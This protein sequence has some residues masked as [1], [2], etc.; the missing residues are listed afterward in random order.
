MATP[1]DDVLRRP[2]LAA[3]PAG[4][5]GPSFLWSTAGEQGW[6]LIAGGWR[7]RVTEWEQRLDDAGLTDAGPTVTPWGWPGRELHSAATAAQPGGADELE[8]IIDE[9]PA[10]GGLLDA[11]G[12]REAVDAVLG[13]EAAAELAGLPPLGSVSLTRNRPLSAG[14]ASGLRAADLRFSTLPY[15]HGDSGRPIQS[16][17]RWLRVAATDTALVALWGPLEGQWEPEHVRWPH[18][19]VPSRRAASLATAAGPASVDTRLANLLADCLEHEQYYLDT[20]QMELEAWEAGIYASLAAGEAV[21]KEIDLSDPVRAQAGRLAS[22]LSRTQ[23]D[24]RAL[25]RRGQVEPLFAADQV[26]AVLQPGLAD[27]LATQAVNQRLRREAFSLLTS[28]A[29]GEQLQASRDQADATHA[30]RQAT[31]GLQQTIT[32]VTALLLAPTVVIG[33]FG[34]NLHEFAAGNGTLVQLGQWMLLAAGISM[35]VLWWR[36]PPATPARWLPAV[37]IVLAAAAITGSI[38]LAVQGRGGQAL[39]WA[40]SVSA[41]VVA[42]LIARLRPRRHRPGRRR[43]ATADR[44]RETAAWT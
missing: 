37:P 9:V 15:R 22:F 16:A 34:A 18:H 40:A 21:L 17:T 31:E 32:W 39:L 27:A 1:P 4:W 44:T 41:W 5:A 26:Q 43:I 38:T 10:G 25:K 2:T 12:V 33:V 7:W 14:A 13:P 19:A 30:Q 36:I 6:R 29:T 24:L 20:W 8:V 23:V 11:D 35:S 28:V 42:S 3:A